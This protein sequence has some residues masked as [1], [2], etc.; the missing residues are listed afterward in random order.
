A[1]GR[2]RLRFNRPA[3]LPKN[4]DANAEAKAG[5]AAWAFRR[6]KRI[7][8][9]G[10]GVRRNPR[11]VV[12][13]RDHHFLWCV[14]CANLNPSR[15]PNLS[16]CLFRVDDQVQEYLDQLA[17]IAND[18]GQA[19]VRLETDLDRVSPQRMFV[20]LKRALDDVVEVNLLFL[21]GCRPRELEEVL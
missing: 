9:L 12:L 8:D 17:G 19:D 15:L 3:V 21:R 2:K 7:K 10:D 5:P 11:A 6:V 16:N 20:K 1:A 14:C 4:R 13:H 18:R